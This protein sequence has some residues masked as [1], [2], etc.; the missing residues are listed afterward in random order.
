MMSGEGEAGEFTV[1][2]G[3]KAAMVRERF[4]ARSTYTDP[5]EAGR[6]AN[7]VSTAPP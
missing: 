6:L 4:A 5:A 1:Q 7:Q 3:G 2:A